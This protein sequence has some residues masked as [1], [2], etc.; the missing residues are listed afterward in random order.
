MRRNL[1]LSKDAQGRLPFQYVFWQ[2]PGT[3]AGG[4][5]RDTWQTTVY[6]DLT[7]LHAPYKWFR[8]AQDQTG[9]RQLIAP[10]Y[11]AGPA[12]PV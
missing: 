7:S 4:T 10:T 9:C 1:V 12:E 5:P 3:K 2:L 11:L 6:E 8:L